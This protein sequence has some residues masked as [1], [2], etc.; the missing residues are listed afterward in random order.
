MG[1]QRKYRLTPEWIGSY[2]KSYFAGDLF[3]G[4]TV[5]V[6]LIPQGM[7]YALIVGV[8]PVYGLYTAVIPPLIYSLLG[9]SRRLSVAP[10]ATDSLMVASGIS[11]LAISDSD[12]YLQMVITLTVLVGLIQVLLGFAKMGFVTNLLSKPVIVGFTAAAAVIIAVSQLKHLLGIPLSNQHSVIETLEAITRQLSQLNWIAI[13]ISLG[14]M[15]II[16]S[17]KK[18][19]QKLPG[20]LIAVL[21][22]ILVV[23]FSPIDGNTIALLQE[24]PAGLPGLYLPSL[25]M[26]D[27]VKLLPLAATLGL[28]GFMESY[29]IAKAVDAD[30][31]TQINPNRELMALGMANL[32]GAFFRTFPAAGG[33]SR[34]A[35]NHQAGANTPLAGILSAGL[36]AVSLL[37]FSSAFSYLPTAILA[38]IIMISI[39][40]LIDLPYIISLSTVNRI[41]FAILLITFLTTLFSTLV[42][43]ILTG[44]ALSILYLIYQSAYPHIAELGRVKNYHEFRN[45]KRFN[46]L[47]QWPNLIIVRVDSSLSFINIQFLKDYVKN[48][49]E[50]ADDQLD[51]FILDA[52]P[53][54][55]MDATAASGLQDILHELHDKGIR[56]IVCDMIGPVRD[57]F[58]RSRLIDH[59]GHD[60]I[61]FDLN[62]AVRAANTNEPGR[63][64]EYALQ[65]NYKSNPSGE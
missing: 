22:S 52:G 12:H 10:T 5:G 3:A 27:I 25:L 40:R 13:A 14:G 29:S 7:A 47:E 36:V 55:N 59:I 46:D 45:I 53:I 50:Q 35:V 26:E 24:V 38:S 65:S 64:K 41:E 61:F 16:L 2:R 17:L 15:A 20:P 23:Y 51:T 33:F 44:I 8:A 49:I 63:Y 28:V 34:S 9:T 21:L 6:M 58:H 62:E 54:S 32:T 31:A 1:N 4:L 37:L 30:G 19:S 42:S 11:T 56:F 48:A 39:T 18:I 60:N 43:G 57:T